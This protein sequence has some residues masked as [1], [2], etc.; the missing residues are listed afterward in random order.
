MNWTSWFLL[1]VVLLARPVLATETAEVEAGATP[2][3]SDDD[4]QA[5]GS[6]ATPPTTPSMAGSL[7]R[8]FG[9]LVVLVVLVAAAV[10]LAK[11]SWRRRGGSIGGGRHLQLL[12]TLPLGVKRA[13]SLIR[14]GDQVLVVAQTEQQINHLTTLTVSELPMPEV[15]APSAATESAAPVTAAEERRQSFQQ[16][17]REALGR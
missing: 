17:L 9:T 6:A 2:F 15:S 16:R 12:E 4:W 5:A 8:L 1:V 10:W 14:L 13:V 7:A 3:I 11:R